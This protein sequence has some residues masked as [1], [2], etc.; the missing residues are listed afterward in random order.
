[1]RRT[2][3]LSSIFCFALLASGAARAQPDHVDITWLSIANVHFD[4]GRVQIL[5]DG[6]VTRLPQDLF[7]GGGGG[8]AETH[9]PMHSDEAAVR[10]VFDAL[11]GKRGVNVL[12]AGHSHWD[13]TFDSATWARLSGARL[14]GPAT[15]CLQLRAQRIPRARCRPVD[16][17]EAIELAPGVR[18]WV[19]RWNHSGTHEQNPEQ[20]DPIELEAIPKPDASGALRAGVAEDFPNG[21][22]TRAYLFRVDG[23]NGTFSW[24]YQ[25]SA[26]AS[27]LT[28]PI[29]IGGHDFGAP[30]DNLRRALA[31]ARLDSVDLWIATGGADVASLV[32]P[33]AKPKAYLPVHWDGLFAPFK[34]GPAAPFADARLSAM[35]ARARVPLV[36]PAGYADKWRLDPSGIK[37]LDNSTMKRALGLE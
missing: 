9:R 16:G 31:A 36:T 26:G 13:H 23:P 21:G 24:L 18:M 35:L 11:G 17:G 3:G 33:V 19:I 1:M 29:V 6:Y 27:D 4:L 28:N 30:L 37:P 25:D 8:F 32:L 15:A 12:L 7:F 5:A 22:G 2:L 34:P 14:L 20:H 10:E